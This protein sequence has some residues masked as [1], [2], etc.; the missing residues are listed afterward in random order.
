MASGRNDLPMAAAQGSKG[1]VRV[2][3]SLRLRPAISALD[4]S[5]SA[6]PPAVE[7]L[8]EGDCAFR[9]QRFRFARGIVLQGSNLRAPITCHPLTARLSPAVA[10]LWCGG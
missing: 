3:V 6:H 8:D 4:D 5:E 9:A 2:Q 1:K 7:I 10:S